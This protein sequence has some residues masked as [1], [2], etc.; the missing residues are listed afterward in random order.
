MK[1][2]KKYSRNEISLRYSLEITFYGSSTDKAIL[3]I[4]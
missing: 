1:V 3:E 4:S 2:E